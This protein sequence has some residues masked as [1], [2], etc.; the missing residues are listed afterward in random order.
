MSP[1]KRHP[2][3][4]T[5]GYGRVG[6]DAGYKRLCAT[7]VKVNSACPDTHLQVDFCTPKVKVPKETA[8]KKVW[9]KFVKDA[10]WFGQMDRKWHAYSEHVLELHDQ[11]KAALELALK[12]LG[13]K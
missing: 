12:N 2:N 1:R 10:L 8:S 9:V 13:V 5:P 7:C 3:S 11:S 6:P 4:I